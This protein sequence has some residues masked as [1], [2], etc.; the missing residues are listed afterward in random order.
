MDVIEKREFN[1]NEFSV[2]R[3]DT[4]SRF[5]HWIECG[6]SQD[7]IA[8]VG[9]VLGTGKWNNLLALDMSCK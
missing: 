1:L 6:L 5:N 7:N 2:S 3:K 4:F 9:N 8:R